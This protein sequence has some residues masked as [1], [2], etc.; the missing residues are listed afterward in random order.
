MTWNRFTVRVVL[1]IASA[2]V[3]VAA[4][5]AADSPPTFYRDVLPLL[6]DNCQECH[7]ESGANY[8]G[9][10]APMA[11]TSYES[12]RPWARSIA[13]QVASRE[14]PP[15]D[16]AP[17][18]NGVFRNERTL[19]DEQIATLV[20]WARAGAP[21][22]D[23]SEAPPPRV[24]PASGGWQI[25]EP[26]LVVR[27]PEPF[28]VED[29]VE[30]LYAA[31]SLVLTEEML[32]ED[33]WVVAFQCQPDSQVIHHFNLHLLEPDE[34]GELPPPPEFPDQTQI[35]PSPQNA[36]RY[37]GGVSSGSEANFYPEGYGFLLRKGSRVTFDIHYHKEPGAGTAVWD[38]SSIGFRFAD[39]PVSKALGSGF[40]PLMNFTFAIPPGAESHQVGPLVS[41]PAAHPV[42]IIALMPHAHMRGKAARFVAIYPD[43]TR[44]TLLDVPRYDFEWQTVYYYD[45]LK[46]VP[47][48]T[49]IEY[50]AWYDNSPEK[51]AIY[52]FD[53]TRTVTFGQ[54]STDE[55]VMGFIMSARADAEAPGAETAGDDRRP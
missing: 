50:T 47:A 54:P 2:A 33:R 23:A 44:E 9:M 37:M 10:R 25:G 51:A 35:A 39:E 8:G 31:F 18:H 42:D 55:M 28:L 34:N 40:A 14:M 26:D 52:G 1:A 3:P 41:P 24:F 29:D 17:E 15:W 53:P 19:D 4:V 38:Q 30:D 22:G 7:R 20:S 46:Q 6:Q 27:M 32:P 11:F 36:G 12:T 16:A 21:A 45:Q 13:R 49:R 48:G 43:G 5:A